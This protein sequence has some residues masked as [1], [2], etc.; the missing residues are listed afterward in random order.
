MLIESADSDQNT[1]TVQGYG[2]GESAE[3]G[4]KK[5]VVWERFN[6]VLIISNFIQVEKVQNVSGS[7]AG[8]GSSEF[9]IY[10]AQRR[11]EFA[12]MEQMEKETQEEK[13][14]RE[15]QE[16]QAKY[17]AEDEERTKKNAAKR[18]KKKQRKEELKRKYE[19]ITSDEKNSCED[20]TKNSVE[21]ESK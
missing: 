10:R 21:I 7:C 18:N 13:E 17:K 12:R 16:K 2:G 6:F 9:D 4:K 14:Q 3:P 15:L 8:A 5:L 1:K 20:D 19:N 11:R